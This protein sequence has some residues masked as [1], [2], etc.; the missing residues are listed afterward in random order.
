MKFLYRSLDLKLD[1]MYLNIL[2]TYLESNLELPFSSTI[3]CS[4]RENL[5]FSNGVGGNYSDLQA[6]SHFQPPFEV[7]YFDD[8]QSNLPEPIPLIKETDQ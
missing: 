5:K 2:L 8:A 6:R 1:S 4:E 3:K 7:S